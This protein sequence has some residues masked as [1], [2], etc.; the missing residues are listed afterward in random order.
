MQ[1]KF[2]KIPIDSPSDFEEQLNKFL[3][4]HQILK[5]EKDFVEK[6]LSWIF[7]I[8][9]QDKMTKVIDTTNKVSKKIKIDYRETLSAEHF[10]KFA[11]LR[12]WR[13]AKAGEQ[14]S[15]LYVVFHNEHL[16]E[17]AKLEDL[18]KENLLKIDGISEDKVAQY[19]ED[20]IKTVGK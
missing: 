17:I 14:G 5:V 15:P 12:E 10:T 13:K 16:A 4:S 7:C 6:S 20:I 3:L 2:F 1:Y 19:F 8:E 11:K 9:Y 18:T